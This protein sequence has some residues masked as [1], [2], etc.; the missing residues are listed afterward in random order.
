MEVKSVQI[1]IEPS[2]APVK[3][4]VGKDNV[5]GITYN[6]NEVTVM[7]RAEGMVESSTPVNLEKRSSKYFSNF[8]FII[9]A[10]E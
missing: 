6:P 5:V 10:E 8:P 7:F 9:V 1:F 2:A 4:L 3:Y